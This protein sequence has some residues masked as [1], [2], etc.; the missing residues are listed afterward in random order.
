LEEGDKGAGVYQV[1]SGLNTDQVGIYN[2]TGV[3][4]YFLLENLRNILRVDLSVPL[5]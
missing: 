4:T 5:G 2:L 3:E 1:V